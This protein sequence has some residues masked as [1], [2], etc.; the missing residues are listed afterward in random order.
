MSR[1]KLFQTVVIVAIGAASRL[2][3]WATLDATTTV[4]FEIDADGGESTAA[5]GDVINEEGQRAGWFWSSND[6]VAPPA[7]EKSA[8]HVYRGTYAWRS[9]MNDPDQYRNE[10]KPIQGWDTADGARFFRFAF[11]AGPDMATPSDW[12]C[13]MQW[14]Q[15]DTSPPVG[16]WMYDDRCPRLRTKDDYGSAT[17]GSPRIR[18]RWTDGEPCADG[19]WHHYVVKIKW[20]I[21]DGE[22]ELWKWENGQWVSKY[23]EA[24]TYIGYHD[25]GM[26]QGNYT[27][28]M[29]GY[30]AAGQGTWD[31]FYDEL[32]YAANWEEVISDPVG[33]N[34]PAMPVI[35]WTGHEDRWGGG[36]LTPTSDDNFSLT[37]GGTDWKK[38]SGGESYHHVYSRSSGAMSGTNYSVLMNRASNTLGS[39]TL[40]ADAWGNGFQVELTENTSN[41]VGIRLGGPV[42]VQSGLHTVRRQTEGANLNTLALA[43]NSTWN[44]AANAVLQWAIPLTGNSGITKSGPGMLLFSGPQLYSGNTY[45]SGGVLGLNGAS[46]NL[47]GDLLF[48]SGAKLRFSSAHTM[49][50]SG[51][52]SF[53]GLFGVADLAGLDASVAFGDYQLISG[54]VDWEHVANL[55]AAEAVLLGNGKRAFFENHAGLRLRVGEDFSDWPR[56]NQGP[57]RLDE[58]R[59]VLTWSGLAGTAYT[60]Q[61]STNVALWEDLDSVWIT[62]S[63]A[64]WTNPVVV[65]EPYRF[66]RVVLDP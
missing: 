7:W 55:G 4:Q 32:K 38:V 50:V 49:T 14:W 30:R 13:I 24:N 66:Y 34:A 46:A 56:P 54:P 48:A 42:A 12:T 37:P 62:A 26:E 44:V 28:K 63:P 1:V 29:G 22:I 45:V 11:C 18:S 35:Y 10:Q 43:T 15:L 52:V 59:P 5:D 2:D 40:V 16:I 36:S 21:T 33:T 61:C 65:T 20:G 47:A 58:G 6:G 25:E 3:A 57:L 27:W 8:L 23:S 51:G 41:G 19:V 17:A 53:E 39:L 9:V 31:M 60:I 64:F